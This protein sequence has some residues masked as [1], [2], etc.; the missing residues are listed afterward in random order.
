[1]NRLKDKVAIITGAAMGMGLA[2][3]KLFASEGA[4]VVIADMNED[5]GKKQAKAI[6]E[7]GGE[8]SFFKVNVSDSGQVEELVDFTVRTYGKLDVAVNNAARSPDSKPIAEMDEKDFRSVIEIDLIGVALCCKYQIKQML[9]QGKGGSIV[10]IASVSGDRPQPGNPAYVA[11]KHGVVGL[12]KTC[13]LDYA[14][15]NI[16]VNTVAPGSIDT[17]MLQKAIKDNNMDYD[18]T[19][20]RLSMFGRFGKPEEVAHASLWVASD[21]ASFVTGAFI[22]ADGGYLSM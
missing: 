6:N 12:T 4:K 7:A 2:T 9:K 21:D 11:A 22:A 13:A 20:E 18:Q 3:A 10:N 5:E 15:E 19:A 14:K 17:P 8:A 1:M 16:R